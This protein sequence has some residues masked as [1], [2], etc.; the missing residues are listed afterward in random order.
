MAEGEKQG[1]VAAIEAIGAGDPPGA[2]SAGQA[3]LFDAEDAP[4]PLGDAVG[5]SG[6]K[7]GRPR[8]SR[9]RR[10]AEWCDYIL[11]Q[12]RSPLVVM[13][14]TYSMPVEEL[15]EKLG[16]DKLD[17]FKAQQ[18]AAAALAPYIHQRQPQAIELPEHT[19][20]LLVIGDLGADGA[21]DALSIPFAEVV[22]NQP[23]SDGDTKKS[24]EAKSRTEANALE[25]KDDLSNG[26]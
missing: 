25:F 18:A 1:A 4:T 6:P 24:D 2:G 9:N 19:R 13:A 20:G 10:T 21:A 16:C 5:R 11:G 7:G 14:E 8:G 22:E 3:E 17:A 23:L 26:Q 15:A 12:Y